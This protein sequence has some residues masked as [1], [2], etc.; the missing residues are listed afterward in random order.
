MRIGIS[1]VSSTG[2]SSLAKA[3]ARAL[4]LPVISE[5]AL[6]AQA[7]EYGKKMGCRFTTQYMPDFTPEDVTVFERGFLEARYAADAKHES[8]VSDQTPLDT[9]NYML[10]F[11]SRT[12]TERELSE[13]T[14]RLE[15]ILKTYDAIWYLPF[16]ILP[17]ENDKRR[18]T[19]PYFLL[20]M[21]FALRGL[22]EF[23]QHSVQVFEMHAVEPKARLKSVLDDMPKPKE[24]LAILGV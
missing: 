16:G 12:F 11:C 4:Q 8:Y 10:T 13:H 2:K 24:K 7:F 21:D 14:E 9:M 1:G 22:R 23:Y 5:D 15:N 6:V 17:I 20:H 3:V 18:T 19:N